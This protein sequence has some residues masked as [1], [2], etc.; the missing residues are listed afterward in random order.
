MPTIFSRQSKK[1]NDMNNL[2]Y[3]ING[4][5]NSVIDDLGNSLD[6]A[7]KKLKVL[8]DISPLGSGYIHLESRTGVYR[9]AQEILKCLLKYPNLDV[10]VTAFML[11][12][13]ECIDYLKECFPQL[14]NKFFHRET[15]IKLSDVALK[16]FDVCVSPYHAIPA[17]FRYNL[18][19]KKI[20][21]I[22]DLIQV[23]HPEWVQEQVHKDYSRFLKKL[24]PNTIALCNSEYTKKD[25]LEYKTKI[26]PKNVSTIPLGTDKKYHPDYP[27]NDIE[28]AKIKYGIGN[29]KY[30][31][32]V[33]SLN[34]R[35]NFKNT[36]LSF[37]DFIEKNKIKDTVLALVGP[38]GWGN[39]FEG[40]DLEKYKEQIIFTGYVDEAD[41]PLLYCGA[42]G[43]VFL[44]L[45]EGFGLPPLESIYCNVPPIASNLTSI[46]EV[47][48][49]AGILLNPMDL[50]ALSNAYKQLYDGNFDFERFKKEAEKQKSLYNWENFEKK[51]MEVIL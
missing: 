24:T 10:Y 22:H 17:I 45:Y 13:S 31:L 16:K 11:N 8:F 51:L 39:I 3:A 2:Q 19:M 27:L 21:I 25:L 43:S 33:S 5:K 28:Q 41:L 14:I 34:P 9:V 36:V 44:S 15:K 32:S 26:N 12:D 7:L 48:G 40:V 1:G 46:P 37:I 35:K 4:S 38:K 42:I 20:I 18:W 47:V 23:L 49:K 50:T 30:F 6:K 29:K